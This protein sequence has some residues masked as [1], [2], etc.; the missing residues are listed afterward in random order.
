MSG[1]IVEGTEEQM[2]RGAMAFL[3]DN[4]S[5]WLNRINLSTLIMDD[6]RK[7]VLGQLYGNYD[8]AV[9]SLGLTRKQAIAFG[10]SGELIG[11]MVS[12]WQRVKMLWPRMIL[13]KRNQ[14]SAALC[15]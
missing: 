10:F 9:S 2:I 8:D 14:V 1:E 3:D 13:E 7:C 12:C 4:C 5:G 15:S 6:I 11:D